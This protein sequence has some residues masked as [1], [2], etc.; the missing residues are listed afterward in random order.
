MAERNADDNPMLG[1]FEWQVT[2]L[3]LAHD[4]VDPV[5]PADAEAADRRRREAEHEASR[6]TLAIVPQE[7]QMNP[8]LDWPPELMR[9]IT[10]ATIAHAA[11]R[12]AQLAEAQTGMDAPTQD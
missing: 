10:A 5:D 8:N 12:V 3:M 4:L 9:S 11:E 1:Y 7:L 6:L 2:T